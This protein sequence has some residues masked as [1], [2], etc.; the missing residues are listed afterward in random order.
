MQIVNKFVFKTLNKTKFCKFLDRLLAIAILVIILYPSYT[1]LAASGGYKKIYPITIVSDESFEALKKEGIIT[2][3]GTAN[4]PYILENVEIIVEGSGISVSNTQSYFV[5]RKCYI[6]GDSKGV[7]VDIKSA[8]N[9]QIIDCIIEELDNGIQ[10]EDSSNIIVENTKISECEAGVLATSSTDVYIRNNNINSCGFKKF[11]RTAVHFNKVAKGEIVG[12]TIEENDCGIGLFESE[13]IIVKDNFVKDNSEGIRLVDSR[14]IQVYN[15]YFS[16]TKNYYVENCENIRWFVEKRPGRN[17]IGGEYIAGNYWSDYKGVDLDNDGIGDTEL[18]YGPGDEMPL[19]EK[20]GKIEECAEN[21]E[22]GD[23][24]YDFYN[25]SKKYENI[26]LGNSTPVHPSFEHELKLVNAAFSGSQSVYGMAKVVAPE[27]TSHDPKLPLG[28]H[29]SY[30]W[31]ISNWFD[32]SNYQSV[33]LYMRDIKA[34]KSGSWGYGDYI[35]LVFEDKDGN[36]YPNV[37][38]SFYHKEIYDWSLYAFHEGMEEKNSYISIET[39]SDGHKWYKYQVE[40]PD[41]MR[42]KCIRVK[43]LWLAQN[44]NSWGTEYYNSISSIVDRIILEERV[45]KKESSLTIELSKQEITLGDSITIIGLL[46]PGMS[47]QITI[48][49]KINGE[50]RTIVTV[51][52]KEDG[53]FKYVYT[54]PREGSYLFRAVWNGNEEYSECISNIATLLVKEAKKIDLFIESLDCDPSS[55]PNIGETIVIKARI[56]RKF[57]KLKLGQSVFL[58][59]EA[60]TISG[61]IRYELVYVN[62]ID[63]SAELAIHDYITKTFSFDFNPRTIVNV[64]RIEVIAIID[65]YNSISEEF[66]D[67]N[68]ITQQISLKVGP[69]LEITTDDI[70][71]SPCCPNPGENVGFTV[72]A[73]NKGNERVEGASLTLKLEF[74]VRSIHVSDGMSVVCDSKVLVFKPLSKVD[75]DAG[76]EKMIVFYPP[77]STDWMWTIPPNICSNIRITALIETPEGVQDLNPDNNMASKIM[78]FKSEYLEANLKIVDVRPVLCP[79]KTLERG[80]L[81][82]RIVV[83]RKGIIESS[84]LEVAASESNIGEIGSTRKILYFSTLEQEYKNLFLV[85]TDN[86]VSLEELDLEIPVDLHIRSP[87]PLAGTWEIKVIIDPKNDIY[88]INENDNVLSFSFNIGELREEECLPDLVLVEDGVTVTVTKI[89]KELCRVIVSGTAFNLGY[90]DIG[91]VSIRAIIR[92]FE[93]EPYG[94]TE[95]DMS[96][97]YRSDYYINI[98]IPCEKFQVQELILTIIIDYENAIRESN[99]NNNNIEVR[100]TLDFPDLT[101]DILRIYGEIGPGK[102]ILVEYKV[103][104]LGKF[105]DSSEVNEEC[106]GATI[107]N[108]ITDISIYRTLNPD[109]FFYDDEGHQCWID[110]VAITLPYYSSKYIRCIKVEVQVEL[111]CLLELNLENNVDSETAHLELKMPDI[112]PVVYINI[113]EEGIVQGQPFTIDVY[114]RNLEEELFSGPITVVLSFDSLLPNPLTETIESATIGSD[115]Y[116]LTTF[117]INQNVWQEL[118]SNIPS[119]LRIEL[120]TPIMELNKDNNVYTYSLELLPDLTIENLD[121]DGVTSSPLTSTTL[122]FIPAYYVFYIEV[123]NIGSWS[124]SSALVNIKILDENGEA[125]YQFDD[126][127]I[128]STISPGQSV[129]VSFSLNSE[130][131]KNILETGS[132]YT[133]EFT[134][135]PED[136]IEELDTANN[137]YYWTFMTAFN[138]PPIIQYDVLS[139]ATIAENGVI[140]V[141]LNDNFE[142]EFSIIESDFGDSIDYIEVS[143]AESGEVWFNRAGLGVSE[144]NNKINLFQYIVQAGT[145]TIKIMSLDSRGA[146]STIEFI[147]KVLDVPIQVQLLENNPPL[148]IY[149]QNAKH[150]NYYI[151][152]ALNNPSQQAYTI[153]WKFEPIDELFLQENSWL[154]EAYT[155]PYPNPSIHNWIGSITLQS[156]ENL[157]IELKPILSDFNYY[158]GWLPLFLG[159]AGTYPLYLTIKVQINSE[160]IP[161]ERFDLSFDYYPIILSSCGLYWEETG[162]GVLSAGEAHTLSVYLEYSPNMP[163]TINTISVLEAYPYYQ[164]YP[165]FQGF[166]G[167]YGSE[168]TPSDSGYVVGGLNWVW[169]PINF[170]QNSEAMSYTGNSIMAYGSIKLVDSNGNEHYAFSANYIILDIEPTLVFETSYSIIPEY[171]C[172]GYEIS[173][174]YTFGEEEMTV[175]LE[176]LG[177]SYRDPPNLNPVIFGEGNIITLERGIERTIHVYVEFPPSSWPSNV[178]IGV[179]KEDDNSLLAVIT[180]PQDCHGKLIGSNFLTRLYSF[181]FFNHRMCCA[182]ICW[183]NGVCWALSSLSTESYYG[184]GYIL[185]SFGY[186]YP[187]EAREEGILCCLVCIQAYQPYAVCPP[188]G[189][190]YASCQ[191]ISLTP[192]LLYLNWGR[193]VIFA[194]RLWTYSNDCGAHAIVLSYYMRIPGSNRVRF[195]GYDPNY[196]F[197]PEWIGGEQGWGSGW[198]HV[199]TYDHTEIVFA[200]GL[201]GII[202]TPHFV[203]LYENIYGETVVAIVVYAGVC[204]GCSMCNIPCTP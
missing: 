31:L 192:I 55:N 79:E 44:W 87:E 183:D 97:G 60:W 27:E 168:E 46:E 189:G 153:K 98:D 138:N 69:D 156:G 154:M 185:H 148:D 62:R 78:R 128:E 116:F 52:T 181:S 13:N 57:A 119:Q 41:E 149:S 74:G 203:D 160:W 43:V 22:N 8:K 90:D 161:V 10:V 175:R 190:I 184:R 101:V 114:A 118:G 171:P 134:V 91:S 165:Q 150:R 102:T 152:L 108:N 76:E 5:I 157:E 4:D 140:Y 82:L 77:N 9:I 195:W 147:V 191:E 70:I 86:T 162:D 163:F 40:I 89:N 58:T 172:R 34:E 1:H 158:S 145:Y 71:F 94:D 19:V 14:N 59:I 113:G 143:N 110:T 95:I 30:T 109:F 11:K 65:P 3:S 32:S 49:M 53:S 131:L 67:N 132:T 133:F 56:G 6:H 141:L 176:L 202:P 173:L 51:N 166:F 20:T 136:T 66:E 28:E 103:V 187:F 38:G 29:R 24:E 117:S 16:N 7:A 23:F 100:K 80:Y 194:H 68:E 179:F 174:Y 180:I 83:F 50:W 122:L 73:R 125:I 35:L 139:S 33:V 21:L 39:G 199:L 146:E 48:E 84:V 104:N 164:P 63:V 177:Y 25:W 144:Y 93:G 96:H 137:V 2:G 111:L 54:P 197:S 15:N 12:N 72:Y 37:R 123:S 17:I 188:G 201:L 107:R 126:V 75:L 124:V 92:N 127:P 26:I 45:H 85:I 115:D 120:Q 88:E 142:I 159:S 170:P 105:I 198:G 99:E 204:V 178:N 186:Q 121:I 47:T 129:T 112:I 155:G 200:P 182:N 130:D 106:I 81:A 36:E 18:P 196:P 151:R 135:Y 169:A 193:P 167:I 42:G 61:S 64:D